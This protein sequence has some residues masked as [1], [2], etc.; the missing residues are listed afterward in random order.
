MT[1]IDTLHRV[2]QNEHLVNANLKFCYVDKNKV[3][4]KGPYLAR[5]NI[6]SDFVKIEELDLQYAEQYMG[7]G[8]SIQASRICA[9]DVDHCFTIPFDVA[10]ADN[11]A[12][13]I[14]N[15]FT[16]NPTY[17][18]FSFS[19]TG[20]RI[21]FR[22][23]PIPDYQTKY[24]IKNSKTQCEYYFP[25]G[26]N[27]YVTVT[28][29]TIINSGVNFVPDSILKQFLNTY[30]PRR[31]NATTKPETG[32]MWADID[33]ALKHFLRCDKSFQDNWFDPAPGSGANESERDFFLLK[34]IFENIT[35]DKDKMKELFERSPF[36]KSK[37]KKHIYKWTH[38][39]G[40]YYEYL[41]TVIS[42]GSYER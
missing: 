29:K 14:I 23:A 11:R 16:A 39:N 1:A 13:E 37:D 6:T 33:M 18:E 20:L 28:G 21:L 32:S 2:L 41:Y 40:R 25:E 8:I 27:R 5:P 22:A 35:T 10:S 12:Q 17:C 3:P 19:G 36:F 4:Y 34:F 31:I 7:L 30:M 9:I 38:S 24:Y 42:G 15:I 26:S